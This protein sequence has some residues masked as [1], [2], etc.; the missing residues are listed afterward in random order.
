MRI[1]P[2]QGSRGA[3]HTA[4]HRGWIPTVDEFLAVAQTIANRR[5]SRA[6]RSLELH[7]RAIFDEEGVE[8]E[9]GQ[10]TEA[11]RK[12]DFVFPSI[13]AYRTGAPTRM[14]GVKTSVKE[15]WRQVLDEAAKIPSKHLFTLSEGV[16]PDQFDQMAGA[17]LTLVIP[18]ANL[19]KFPQIVRSKLL[20]LSQFVELV[21]QDP[22]R[23]AR[24]IGLH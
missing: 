20:T 12:P 21:T 6:G 15:R 9:T 16:S 19:G 22:R 10:T 24:S 8:Y 4:P 7:L 23:D 1:W 5:K 11:N 18:K 17:G 13:N 3:S 2:L 14:L